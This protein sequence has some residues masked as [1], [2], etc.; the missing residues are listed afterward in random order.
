MEELAILDIEEI[1]QKLS[2]NF[3]SEND[4]KR[5]TIV[6]DILKLC[7]TDDEFLAKLKK[8]LILYFAKLANDDLQIEV[9]VLSGFSELL[10][11]LPVVECYS[12]I[13]Y[14]IKQS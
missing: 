6:S 3:Y 12:S 8:S 4:D 14:L 10:F 5:K 13:A 2:F 1:V 7:K 9:T 11:Q